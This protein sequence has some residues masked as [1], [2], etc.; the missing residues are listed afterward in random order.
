MIQSEKMLSIGGLAA[1]MA[2]EINNPLSGMIQN[3]QLAYNRLATDFPA[4][5]KAAEE[6]GVSLESIRKYAENRGILKQ[7]SN[8]SDGG[9][10]AAKIIENMLSYSQKSDRVRKETSLEKLIDNT[11]ALCGNE[12]DLKKKYNFS[13]IE[14]IREYGPDLPAIF[15]E[16][17]K[18]QQVLFNLFKNASDSMNLKNYEN[19]SPKLT[20]RLERQDK[21]IQIQVEDNGMGMSPETYKHIFEPFFQRVLWSAICLQDANLYS[22]SG[23]R[24]TLF[25]SLFLT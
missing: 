20:I 19:E 8:I 24:Y 16:K 10:H 21:N 5:E 1:G 15:C 17:S 9:E 3:A 25:C 11:I 23:C 18:I 14:I 7:L 6:I 13:K 2:H 22:M 12:Y 4:N